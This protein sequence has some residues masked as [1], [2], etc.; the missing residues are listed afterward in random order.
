L[1]IDGLPSLKILPGSDQREL[2]ELIDTASLS[3]YLLGRLDTFKFPYQTVGHTGT[4]LLAFYF[5]TM[6]FSAEYHYGNWRNTSL[7]AGWLRIFPLGDVLKFIESDLDRAPWLTQTD[8][9]FLLGL[10]A[11]ALPELTDSIQ[12]DPDQT[13]L[14]LR[15]QASFNI[16]LAGQGYSVE[17]RAEFIELAAERAMAE[18][19]Q[20]LRDLS[21]LEDPAAQVTVWKAE[22]QGIESEEQFRKIGW[23]W[24]EHGC[25]L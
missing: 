7:Q 15:R 10:T 1:Q 6:I 13:D 25:F 4:G 14:R 22:M 18:A 12:Q 2:D 9:D 11:N 23:Q 19:L 24:V 21:G 5:I 8:K 16:F 17:N 3:L 20:L